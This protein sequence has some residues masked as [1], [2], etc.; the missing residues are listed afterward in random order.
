MPV[1]VTGTCLNI[2][3]YCLYKPFHS[4]SMPKLP[5]EYSTVAITYW[6]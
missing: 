3:R 4:T 2:S 5:T 1:S 6:T